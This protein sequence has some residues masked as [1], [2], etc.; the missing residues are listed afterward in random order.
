MQRHVDSFLLFDNKLAAIIN[1]IACFF[2][3][4]FNSFISPDI[5]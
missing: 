3:G 4:F 1:G 2:L 5:K